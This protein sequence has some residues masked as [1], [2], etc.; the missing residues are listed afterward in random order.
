MDGYS[1]SEDDIIYILKCKNVSL[2][3][4]RQCFII[5][6]SNGNI[7][8]SVPLPLDHINASMN[9]E[10]LLQG[11]IDNRVYFNEGVDSEVV[12]YLKQILLMYGA[13]EDKDGSFICPECNAEQSFEVYS[14]IITPLYL[15]YYAVI[16]ELLDGEIDN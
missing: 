16:I 4:F 2:F 13:Q 12:Q 8:S 3:F 7:E 5:K 14:Q 10:K 11:K 9:I 1:I 6:Y 15:N